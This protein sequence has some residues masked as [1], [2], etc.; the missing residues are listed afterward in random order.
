[1][2][3]PVFWMA[4]GAGLT[5][6]AIRLWQNGKFKEALKEETNAFKAGLKKKL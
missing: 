3:E 1:M 2:V 5:Y 6:F 4:V